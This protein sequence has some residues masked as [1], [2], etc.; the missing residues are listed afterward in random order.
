MPMSSPMMK[1]MLGFCGFCATA[2]VVAGPDRD[3]NIVALSSE[4]DDRLSQLVG[5]RGTLWTLIS[6]FLGVPASIEISSV[7]SVRRYGAKPFRV[8]LNQGIVRVGSNATQQVLIEVR[9]GLKN[10]LIL[11]PDPV[12]HASR[13]F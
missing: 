11:T 12:A 8:D 3:I 6:W 5:L 9:F 1:T 2:G 7:Y 13:P 4:A 10:D